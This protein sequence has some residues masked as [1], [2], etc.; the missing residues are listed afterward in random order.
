MHGV[1][2]D[3][4]DDDDDDE[5][6]P[7]AEYPSSRRG[8]EM[9]IGTILV[10]VATLVLVQVLG[11]NSPGKKIQFV[12]KTKAM[13]RQMVFL[14]EFQTVPQASIPASFRGDAIGE[15][16]RNTANKCHSFFGQSF[17]ESLRT[18]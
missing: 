1:L 12:F 15:G 10:V 13:S 17:L 11:G 3:E 16:K 9:L 4:F 5:D 18:Q 7:I 14:P 2:E 6:I 8:L